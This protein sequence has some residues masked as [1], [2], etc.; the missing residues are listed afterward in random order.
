V[1]GARCRELADEHGKPSLT[2]AARVAKEGGHMNQAP[3]LMWPAATISPGPEFGVSKALSK[4]PNQCWRWTRRD[5][6]EEA[7][8]V[9]AEPLD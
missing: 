1:L 6:V 5:T 8:R 4:Y 3:M 9:G 2:A 7:G